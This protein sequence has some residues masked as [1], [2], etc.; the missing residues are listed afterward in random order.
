MV[1]MIKLCNIGSI[2]SITVRVLMPFDVALD[3]V[4][5]MCQSTRPNSSE[6]DSELAGK[7]A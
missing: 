2:L 3:T 6:I 7:S 1:E 5:C 4:V